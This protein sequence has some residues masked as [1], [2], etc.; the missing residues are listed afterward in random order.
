MEMPAL[1]LTDH[2]N[3]YGAIEFYKAAKNAGVKPIIGLEA[4]VA[5][6]SLKDKEPGVDERRY[7]LTL[8][9]E[10][11]EGYHNLIELVTTS[12]LEGFYYKPRVDKDLL[13]KHSKGII[14]L[15]GCMSGEISRAILRKDSEG[16][17]RLIDEYRG[18]FGK[19]NFF[20]EISHHPGI[21]AHEEIQK[22]LLELSRQTKTPLV[23]TQDSHYLRA[24]D[25]Q[26][27]DILLAVQTN[28]KIDNEDRLTMKADDFSFRSPKIMRELFK[29]LPEAIENTLEI[30]NRVNLTIP[31]GVLQL[32]HYDVP[33][34]ISPEKYLAELCR[35]KLLKKYPSANAEIKNRLDYELGVIGKTG[36]STYFL[37]VQDFVNWARKEGIVV[38]PGRGSAAGSL[39]SYVLGITNIDPIAYNLIFERFMNPDRISPPDIDLDFADTGRDRVLEYVRNKYG[40][41]KV[42]SII[43]FGTMAARAA[44][45]DAGRAL[46][47][48]Y[49]F[50]DQ[51]AKLIPFNPTQGMKEGWLAQC[52]EDV[53]ELKNI[54]KENAE[55][56]RLIDSALKL[57]GVARHASVHACG[58]V[59]TKDPLKNIVPLQYATG[60]ENEG[61]VI[62]TQ[63]EMHAIEDLGLLKVDFLGLKNLT[64]IENTLS[65]VEKRHGIALNLDQINH[66]DPNVFRTLAEGKTIG[67]FQLEGQ[68]MTR[69]LKDLWPTNIEDIIAMISLYRPGPMEL[70]PSYIKRKHGKERVTYLHPKL[71]PILKN[72]YGIA[73]YQEQLMQIAQSLAGFTLAEADTLRKAVGKKIRSLLEEQTEKFVSRMIENKIEKNI[74]K[75]LGELLE[76]FARYGFNRSHA[77]SYAEVAYQTAF[78]KTYYPIEFMTSLMNA[79]EKDV[80]RI[81]FLIKEAA[82]LGIEVLAPAINNSDDGFTPE[83]RDNKSAIRF[84]LRAI[85]NVGSN[86]VRAIIL[87]RG[88]RGRFV[89]LSDF[90]ERVPYQD[91]NKKSLEALIKSGAMDS[92]GERAQMLENMET[93][94]AHH[95]DS[96]KGANGSQSSLFGDSGQKIASTLTLNEF[97]PATQE[98][99]LRWEKELLGLFVSGH[100]LEKFRQ[101]LEKQKL[102]IKMAK[103][104][105]EGT[106]VIIGGII[107]EFKKVLTK[108]NQPMLF[109]KIADLSDSIE[110][111]VFPRLLS[112]NGSVFGL[113]NCVVIKGKVSIRNGNPS[114]ICEE[115]RK[116]GEK[117]EEKKDREESLVGR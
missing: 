1:A 93:L 56:K 105:N 117:H 49:A 106:P 85:K 11:E 83:E 63:Y 3:M 116:L 89:S 24:D 115:A 57:E 42:A 90:L 14:A 2:G 44:I 61:A 9:A 28:S 68:G 74:A 113:D 29:D 101:L 41:D 96:T 33:G 103:T 12:N 30:A 53:E 36:F 22:G 104:F 25:A 73:V 38:G 21:P 81:G 60:D 7:H 13:R 6:R 79:D 19:E 37:M 71:E 95:R 16:A 88:Q 32:P 70:I 26:A 108:Q 55:A 72:T 64:I 114:I 100:P 77:A 87:E 10:N 43:T 78:L 75:K 51:L 98:E 8:L 109:L 82:E 80:E 65:L 15:S 76:P 107:D 58:V 52:L 102:N 110:A 34:E 18:I 45:R 111:V 94:L 62:V 35:G 54:Y 31:M 66:E 27:Q 92:L 91:L 48:P 67:V 5:A 40:G 20:L 17:E 99:K 84:G 39:V 4:Y 47:I 86:V 50:C 112:N 23:A 59:I 69:Y 46:G 97:P